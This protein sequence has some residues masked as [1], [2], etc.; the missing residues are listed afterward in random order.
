MVLS[1]QYAKLCDVED[2]DERLRARV[3]EIVPGLEG[4]ADL[5]R[6]YWE[7]ATLTFFL[8]DV[9]LTEKTS[10]LSV[11][12]GHEEVLFWLANH[13][14]RVVATDIYGEGDFEGREAEATMLTNPTA[15]APYS[16]REDRLEVAHMDARQLEYP[17]GAFD[18]VFT[19]SSIEHFGSSE[20]IGRAARELARV[21]RPGGHAFVVTECF[22]EPKLL[23]S[24]IVQ[25]AGR[26]AS[27]GRFWAKASLRRRTIDVF[28]ADEINQWIVI[29]SGL[30]LMQ[31]VNRSV[32]LSSL[33]NV[34]TLRGDEIDESVSRPYPHVLIQA[35][36]AVGPLNLTTGRWTSVALP[37]EKHSA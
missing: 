32:S 36:T 8:E 22:V 21:L 19:L 13:A 26:V 14:G 3:R 1:R 33:E 7:Y 28:T 10:I 27:F 4:N 18:A 31:P 6:K 11:G 15:F 12:A 20:D 30:R 17:D 34:I 37:L 23:D 2:F 16:Y 5:H 29:T 25:A 35:A 9:G 24:R